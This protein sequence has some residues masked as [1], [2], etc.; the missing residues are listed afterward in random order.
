MHISSSY[1]KILGETIFAHGRF[2]EVGQKQKTKKERKR[3]RAKVGDHNGQATHGA[4]KHAWHTQA[5]WAKT[6][7][8]INSVF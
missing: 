6:Q 1:A 5:A 4:R 2:P 3:E 8:F 7:I